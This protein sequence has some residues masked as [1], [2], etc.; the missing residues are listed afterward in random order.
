M[1]RLQTLTTVGLGIIVLGGIAQGWMTHRWSENAAVADAAALLDAVPTQV[2][3]WTSV[4]YELSKGEIEIGRIDGYLKREYTNQITGA[5]VHFLLMVGE[6]GPI[7]LHP[8]TICFAGQ[9]YR[10]VGH[11][12][13]MTVKD[14]RRQGR[15]FHDD[16]HQAD[17]GNSALNDPALTRLYWAWSASGEWEAP[18][19]PRVEY[20]GKPFLFKLYVS[21]SWVPS[22]TVSDT[23]AARLFLEDILPA[24]RAALQPGTSQLENTTNG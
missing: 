9:G 4:D 20:A 5:R 18:S 21:E 2:G 17:F 15:T 23:G 12:T 24:V 19:N 10:V 7:S 14:E 11:Q 22:G 3:E 16:F 1:N 6:A 8:P 13:H